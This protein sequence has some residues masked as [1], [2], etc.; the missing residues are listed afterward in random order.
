MCLFT[1]CLTNI[2]NVLNI[3]VDNETKEML[4]YLRLHKVRF[5]PNLRKIVKSELS[6]ICKDFNM[7]QKPIKMCLIGIMNKLKVQLW[8]LL[9]QSY[10]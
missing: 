1:F 6:E 3:R 10:M 8:S 7:K 5:Q 9:N 4:A 2:Y